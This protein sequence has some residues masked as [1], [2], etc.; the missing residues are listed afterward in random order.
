MLKT[1]SPLE[2]LYSDLA[3]CGENVAL[4]ADYT[5]HCNRE[6]QFGYLHAALKVLEARLTELALRVDS[7]AL[8]AQKEGGALHDQ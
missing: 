8:A 6:E 5:L 7:C 4:L 3:F 1:Q 2:S